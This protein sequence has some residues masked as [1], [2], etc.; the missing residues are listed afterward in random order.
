MIARAFT[1]FAVLASATAFAA[2]RTAR[3]RGTADEPQQLATLSLTRAAWLWAGRLA[4][5]LRCPNLC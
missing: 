4:N 1:L 2:A 5:A 3:T